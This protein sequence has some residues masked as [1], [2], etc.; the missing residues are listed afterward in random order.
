MSVALAVAACKGKVP[1]VPT[2]P[3]ASDV[4]RNVRRDNGLMRTSWAGRE[5][6]CGNQPLRR[7]YHEQAGQTRAALREAP[8]RDFPIAGEAAATNL[9]G[10]RYPN[11]HSCHRIFLRSGLTARV[12]GASLKR[13]YPIWSPTPTRGFARRP[14]ASARLR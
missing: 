1:A 13:R 10:H 12:L 3:T 6:A 8:K 2:A 11:R 14:R 5:R 4:L 7:W 9:F